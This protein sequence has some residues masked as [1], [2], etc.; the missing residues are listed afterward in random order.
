METFNRNLYDDVSVKS[1]LLDDLTML[2]GYQMA[3]WFIN[4]GKL[5]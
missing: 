4:K 5:F 1:S 3:V 2:V